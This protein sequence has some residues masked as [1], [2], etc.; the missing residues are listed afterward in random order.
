[1]DPL[2]IGLSLATQF[3]PSLIRRLAG[4]NNSDTA[5]RIISIGRTLTGAST[6][7]G[8]EP[9]LVADPALA[10][11]FRMQAAALD[12]ELEKAYLADTQNARQRD[13][14]FLAAG[15]RN[16]RADALAVIIVLGLV[17][18]GF[19]LMFVEIPPTS[20]PLLNTLQ[21][22][23]IAGFMG[24]ISFEFGSSRGSKE[25]TAMMGTR[26]G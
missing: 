22:A 17:G 26:D 8:I 9:A 24:I 13:L 10:H 20:M 14:A 21:G 19:A 11:Q 2:S 1:M 25:K 3:A 4:D 18:N 5:E 7:E 16:W 12:V 15:K 23:L 6:D